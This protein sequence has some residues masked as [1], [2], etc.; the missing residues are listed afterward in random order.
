MFSTVSLL[1]I[2]ANE[3]RSGIVEIYLDTINDKEAT[4]GYQ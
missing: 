4:V 1:R 2:G 3:A